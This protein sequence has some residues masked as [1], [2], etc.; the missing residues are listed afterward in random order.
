MTTLQSKLIKRLARKN[1]EQNGFTLIELMIVVAIIG[2]LTAVGLPELGKAQARAKSSA[3]KAEAVNI[4]KSCTLALL[5]GDATEITAASVS[6]VTSG[7]ITNTAFTCEASD[8]TA[9]TPVVSSVAYT[10]G[11]VTWTVTMDD[12]GVAGLPVES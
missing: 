10:G 12:N 4:G 6:A 9:T 2:V 3:A 7:E 1:K 5:S 8:S 11:G